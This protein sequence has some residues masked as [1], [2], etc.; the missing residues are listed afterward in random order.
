MGVEKILNGST[1]LKFLSVK[2]GDVEI[3]QDEI[4]ALEI[5][6]DFYDFGI[7]GTLKI[8]DS[9][10][11]TNNG[12]IEFDGTN[13]ITIS[14]I[15]FL[16]HR[17]VR[18]YRIIA[19]KVNPDTERFKI[20]DFSFEDEITFILKNTY[21]SK[22]FTAKPVDA[23]KEYFTHL[24]IDDIVET[25]KISYN[26]A[27][28]G[29]SR[30]F[31]VPQNVSVLDHFMYLFKREN[32]RFWQD[33]K[34]IHVNRLV[35]SEMTPLEDSNGVVEYS[36][37][38][39]NNEY[40]FK[41]HD[42]QEII[43]HTILTN[44]LLP[45]ETIYRYNYVK[46]IV[47]TT[48]NLTDEFENLKLNSNKSFDNSDL[49]QTNGSKLVTQGYFET[50]GQ[51]YDLFDVYMNNNLLTIAVPG[52]LEFSN[53]GNVAEIVLKGN[54]LYAKSDMENNEFSSGRYFISRVSDRI[55]ADKMINRLTLIRVDSV[56]PG[57]LR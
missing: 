27:D 24:G 52:S 47:D 53:I 41:I 19:N 44:S 16:E 11:L 15:D 20:L 2:I 29:T 36:N 12:L 25:D 39:G 5:K 1:I 37:K 42:T 55:I 49:Q 6:Q 8:K 3:P 33:R 34:G 54:P 21:L 56:K 30:N 31:V 48:L 13:T 14:T 23:L 46:E 10:D 17:S 40:I 22:G 50:G 9:F 45:K 51:T 32:I 57:T 7:F 43:N 26:L 35:P 38:V 18:T 28:V 4:I